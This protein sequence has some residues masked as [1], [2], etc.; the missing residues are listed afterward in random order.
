MKKYCDI[1]LYSYLSWHSVQ[2]KYKYR[3]K[4][5]NNIECI[6]IDLS[7]INITSVFKKDYKQIL[8]QTSYYIWQSI[9]RFSHLHFTLSECLWLVA[10]I[11]HLGEISEQQINSKEAL[12]IL[13]NLQEFFSIKL[14]QNEINISVIYAYD[15]RWFRIWLDLVDIKVAML[16]LGKNKILYKGKGS[17]SNSIEVTIVISSSLYFL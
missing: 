17:L 14:C 4:Y 7:D 2:S 15:L 8:A 13:Q 9:R 3:G 6:F 1:N 5:L 11:G 12:T 16:I 10:N